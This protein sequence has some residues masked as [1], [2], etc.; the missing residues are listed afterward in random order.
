M[1][2]T[3]A[4]VEVANRLD[5]IAAEFHKSAQAF[6]ARHRKYGRQLDAWSKRVAAEATAIRVELDYDDDTFDSES[7][8]A[9]AKSGLGT[10]Q[11]ALIVLAAA[12]Q[13]TGVTVPD[14]IHAA[15][16]SAQWAYNEAAGALRG[17]EVAELS[18]WEGV[19]EQIREQ[20][21]SKIEVS[22]VSASE[23]SFLIVGASGSSTD[24][25]PKSWTF[26]VRFEGRS[27]ISIFKESGATIV[28]DGA[29]DDSRFESLVSYFNRV[30]HAEA[31]LHRD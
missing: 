1:A 14:A 10:A 21:G 31:E 11:R 24:R 30:I 19:A 8:N 13:A 6:P 17:S 16:D 27:R 29:Q 25:P 23:A 4:L 3:A 22:R 12:V 20:T 2:S 18:D 5:Q 28:I 7:A 15:Y 9:Q 26:L